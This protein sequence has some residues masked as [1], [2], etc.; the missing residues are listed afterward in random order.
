MHFDRYIEYWAGQLADKP[1]M[2]FEGTVLTWGELDQHAGALAARLQDMGI[3]EGDRVGILLNNCLEWA[4][5]FVAVI[6]CGAATVPLN[7]KYGTFELQAI[8]GDAD[9]SAMVSRP[10]E[11]AKLKQ[12]WSG[13]G[14]PVLLYDLVGGEEPAS[15]DK[16]ISGAVPPERPRRD[17]A[18]PLVLTY[19]SGTTGLPKGIILSHDAVE[20]MTMRVGS[21][22]GWELEQER[23]LILAPL[24]FTG[25]VISNLAV[26]I[27]IGASSWLEPGVQPA[28]ALQ[29]IVDNRL[30][31]L[32]GVP[33]LWERI[34][35]APGF[36]NA[37]I[38][39]LKTAIT[40]GASVSMELVGQYAEK[41]V[42]IR[43]QFGVSENCGCV[44]SA[45]REAALARPHS[46]GPALP[47]IDLQI[48]DD[49]GNVVDDG[50]VG[51][52][53]IRSP[54]LMDG[55]W[56]NAEATKAAIRDGWYHTGD[57]G[58]LDEDGG[59]VVADRKKNM[60]ISGGVN[61]YPAEIERAMMTIAGIDEVVVTGRPSEKWGQEVVAIVHSSTNLDP[62]ETLAEARILLGSMKAPKQVLFSPEPLPRTAS[63]KIA[64]N[65]LDAICER[66]SAAG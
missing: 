29:R 41:G 21:R 58:Y 61:I 57:V 45:S 15:F 59:L 32:A 65:G 40:G 28:A 20:T 3:G 22:F 16:I 4:I 26:Q 14:D 55:Y 50:V 42:V 5:G 43:Q 11:M 1:F 46:C 44:A 49:D 17:G 6:R 66:L 62:T 2:T 56:K 12:D 8:A 24:A 36:A 31:M 54:Q 18:S 13:E 19:T 35:T 39:S 51:E 60:L 10:S 38:T 48:R 7:P 52:I 30:T 63:D 47:G 9:L 37:D 53:C 25:G 27:V 23:I 33:A 64:R 34:A